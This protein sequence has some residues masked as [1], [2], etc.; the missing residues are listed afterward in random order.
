MQKLLHFLLIFGGIAGTIPVQNPLRYSL[1]ACK[2]KWLSFGTFYCL[3]FTIF[4]I[5]VSIDYVCNNVGFRFFGTYGVNDTPPLSVRIINV[6][7][8][9]TSMTD[10]LFLRLSLLWYAGGFFRL[11]QSIQ[12][13]QCRL[14]SL[15][16]GSNV[17][18]IM[19]QGKGT[20][21]LKNIFVLMTFGASGAYCV[22]QSFQII[23]YYPSFLSN[24]FQS[25]WLPKFAIVSAVIGVT[26]DVIHCLAVS[27]ALMQFTF[28]AVALSELYTRMGL[29]FSRMAYVQ[30]PSTV[31]TVKEGTWSRGAGEVIGKRL[32]TLGTGML[33]GKFAICDLETFELLADSITLFNSVCG[34][35]L[36]ILI[37][38]GTLGVTWV[39]FGFV[40]EGASFGV[41]ALIANAMSFAIISGL[42]QYFQ[43][44]VGGRA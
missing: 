19:R 20:K 8:W 30:R 43:N 14:A 2:F 9:C 17:T 33:S 1:R 39:I 32:F 15:E 12:L 22:N 26:P 29:C 34:F 4:V 41:S 40:T 44:A 10:L 16:G 37:T 42:G 31:A 21:V 27:F 36:C 11:L 24:T 3:T 25:W 5:F 18:K 35:N 7:I 13:V 38:T 28:L 23:K 6:V